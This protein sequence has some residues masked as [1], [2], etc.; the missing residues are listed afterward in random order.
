MRNQIFNQSFFKVFQPS[1][2]KI[3]SSSKIRGILVDINGS[4]IK[5]DLGKNKVMDVRLKQQIDGTIGDT[6]VIDRSN[7][8]KSE[9][10]AYEAK[11]KDEKS[12]NILRTLQLPETNESEEA[13]K[14]LEKFNINISKNNIQSFV[15][16]KRQL[17][18]VIDGLDYDT[19][20]KLMEKDINIQSDS[21]QKIAEEIDSIKSE[22]KSFSFSDLFK[23][24]KE[25]KNEDA[26]RLALK[27]YGSKMGKDTIDAMKSLHKAGLDV[28]KENVDK[29][30][31]ILN[32]VDNIQSIKEETLID[33]VKNKITTS[34]DNLYKIKNKIIKGTIQSIGGIASHAA[35][36]YEGQ[37]VNSNI[38][39]QDL[40]LLEE[41]IRKLLADGQ[42]ESTEEIINLSK[43]LVKGGL[44]LTKENIESVKGLKDAVNELK[45]LMNGDKASLLIKSGIDIEKLDIRDLATHL[46]ELDQQMIKHEENSTNKKIEVD[47]I[48]KALE[49]MDDKQLIELVKKGGDIKLETL[50][51]LLNP[52]LEKNV[53]ALRSESSEL[54]TGL[55][56]GFKL[57]N[58]IDRL[59][60]ITNETIAREINQDRP[61]TLE[62][63]S[64][65]ILE[66]ERAINI[67]QEMKMKVLDESNLKVLESTN[68]SIKFIKE[69]LSLQMA[70]GASKHQLKLEGM[71]LIK[72]QQYIKE[73]ELNLSQ[74]MN[75]AEELKVFGLGSEKINV[76]ELI[77]SIDTNTLGFH[78]NNRIP[79][80]LNVLN[81]SRQ[82]LD[83]ELLEKDY[84][85][86]IQ[87]PGESEVSMNMPKA[88]TSEVENRIQ[89]YINDNAM[90]LG[91]I[92][93]DPIIKD[94]ARS[95]IQNNLALNTTNL[96][97][98][99]ER[100]QQ[101][102][103]IVDNLST[104]FIAKLKAENKDILSLDIKELVN[105]PANKKVVSE[106]L[107]KNISNITESQKDSLISLLMKNA[108]P[109]SL[110]EVEGVFKFLN[111]NGQIG[112]QIN[113]ILNI[114]ED[115][116]GKKE[117]NDT[118]TSLKDAL[119]DISKAIKLGKGIP[120]RPYENFAKILESIEGK[121][122]LIDKV[123]RDE[124]RVAGEKLFDSLEVQVKLNRDDTVFQLPY[125]FNDQMK[126]LQMYIMNNKKGSKKIDPN[127]MSLLLNFDTNN[128]GN[129]CIYMG[130]SNKRVN[131]KMGLNTEDDR[132][133]LEKHSERI[134]GLL[135]D[136]GYELKDISYRVDE[137]NSLMDVMPEVSDNQKSVRN[138]IDI[139]I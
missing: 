61:M 131:M 125:M 59:K 130:V 52:N 138:K 82:L 13:L 129:V 74:V 118:A 39:D 101:L 30:N 84:M 108:L 122:H 123:T 63:L 128:M 44:E 29:V 90:K 88:I 43:K 41:D 50:N 51:R 67:D 134:T 121:S 21:I 120:E 139:K 68:D 23:W 100:H 53:D 76:L 127:N 14:T 72:L 46:S 37:F 86:Q 104:D 87:R 116:E 24:K 105:E 9:I 107:I 136:L 33:A 10:I 96:L 18:K 62:H 31:D 75:Q 115:L 48:I 78:I 34:I 57:S 6:V 65:R 79:M 133:L 92:A 38:S 89:S 55:Q 103:K 66:R 71:E 56:Y 117:F 22:K 28:T 102:Q 64:N 119:N 36:A 111:N 77:K 17:N 25:M 80:N 99:Y 5:L 2:G 109:V 73:Y 20:I 95:L 26:E 97:E 7:I 49:K 91:Q 81:A 3:P 112:S 83:G 60:N 54:K 40:R 85:E 45:L 4:N 47:K 106:D 11:A 69:N 93:E 15:S 42:I 8:E 1:Y 126:N 137:Q 58:M 98:I 132:K 114:L 70:L 135:K 12:I 113:D 32:K 27:I 35:R 19:A 16:I 94:F 124:L 110:K